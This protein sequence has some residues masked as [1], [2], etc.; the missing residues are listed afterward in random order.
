MPKK[1]ACVCLIVALAA[2]TATFIACGSGS[3]GPPTKYIA[4]ADSQNSRILLYSVPVVTGQAANFVLG[5]ADFTSSVSAAVNA[6]SLNGP[7]GERC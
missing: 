4:V 6:S 7:A 5:Q 2:I 3:S 1:M